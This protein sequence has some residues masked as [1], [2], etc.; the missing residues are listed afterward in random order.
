MCRTVLLT[1][2][3]LHSAEWRLQ[4]RLFRG[5]SHGTLSRVA[6]PHHVTK[7]ID[8]DNISQGMVEQ[9][10]TSPRLHNVRH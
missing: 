10:E 9:C 7:H 5:V 8:R 1:S 2:D 6:Q 4:L 3:K